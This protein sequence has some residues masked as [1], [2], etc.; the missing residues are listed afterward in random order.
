MIMRP[1]NFRTAVAYRLGVPLL[2]E[3]IPCPLCEQPINIL[4]ITPLAAQSPEISSFVITVF[5]T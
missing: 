1:R 5:E 4:A 3:E 2:K